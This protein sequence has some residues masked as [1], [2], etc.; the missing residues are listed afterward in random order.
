MDEE[1][2]RPLVVTVNRDGAFFVTYDDDRTRRWTGRGCSR[3]RQRSCASTPISRFWSRATGTYLRAVIEAMVLLQ[4]AGAPK[5]GWSPS[6]RGAE[7][8]ALTAMRDILRRNP[9]A[10]LLAVLMHAAIVAFNDRG[11]GL[12]GAAQADPERRR[13]DRGHCDRRL[14]ARAQVEQIQGERR[15]R[16]EQQRREEQQRVEQQRQRSSGSPI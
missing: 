12:A 10:F 15:Q 14:A 7:A 16:A 4:Q 9:L 11:R 3:S 1:A 5:V 8:Q 6:R 13:G 2:K